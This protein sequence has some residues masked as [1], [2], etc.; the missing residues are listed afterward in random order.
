LSEDQK[1]KYQQIVAFLHKAIASGEYQP[2]QKLPSEADLVERFSTSRLT[3]Q[4]ALKELQHQNLIERRAGSGT[5]VRQS[6]CPASHVFGLLIPGLGETEIF[7]PICQGMARAGRAGSNSLLWG[8]TTQSAEDKERQTRELCQYYIA[9]K[10]SGIFF[11]PLELTPSKDEVNLGVVETLSKAGIPIVL[12]D[13]CIYRYPGR[14]AFDLVGIDNR[15]AGFL[16]TE[17]LLRHGCRS[18]MFVAR[19]NSAPTIEARMQGFRDA[20]SAFEAGASRGEVH[21]GEPEDIASIRDAVSNYSPDGIVCANDR[22]AAHLM[23][24]LQTLRIAVPKQIRM[25]GIDDV[26]YASLLAVPLTTLH[27]PWREIGEVAILTML[28][29]IANPELPARDILLDCKLVV[30][31]S[32]GSHS[33][34]EP[35]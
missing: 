22:T 9:R 8:D 32:C 14:S 3:V 7:E 2:G 16:V 27:P 5:Y 33:R 30:R 6:P 28:E 18:L 11:A 12:L 24:T 26:K 15:R 20:L 25:V 1:P 17:H 35:S 21:L 13:R 29:R 23:Q 10:V 4:R 19:P 34:E 31:R